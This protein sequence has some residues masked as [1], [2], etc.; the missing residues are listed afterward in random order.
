MSKSNFH[1]RRIRATSITDQDEAVTLLEFEA[2]SAVIILDSNS[3]GYKITLPA[4]SKK[5]EGQF[6]RV[7][8]GT[9]GESTGNDCTVYVALGFGGS[10]SKDTVTVGIGELADFWCDGLYWYGSSAL[11]PAAT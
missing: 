7:A 5:Y 6:L 10:T 9:G 2:K 11:V 3:A 8:A 1:Q 4:A